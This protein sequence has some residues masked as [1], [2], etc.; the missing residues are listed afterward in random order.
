MNIFVSVLIAVLAIAVGA[1]L[2]YFARQSIA[3]KQAD[4]IETTLQKRVSQV[5]KETDE[6]LA[7]AKKKADQLIESTNKETEAQKREIFNTERVLLKRENILGE[8]ISNLEEK[9][10]E[11]RQKVEKLK[12]VKASLETLR[13]EVDTLIVI[14]NQRLMDVIGKP[15]YKTD[16]R[17]KTNEA[18][19]KKGNRAELNGQLLAAITTSLET[20]IITML[21]RFLPLNFIRLT[22][23]L[24]SQF[25]LNV[26]VK[27]EEFISSDLNSEL[28]F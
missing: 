15:E 9:E 13:E 20:A 2:G 1:V 24:L 22:E 6:M 3:R 28:F 21:I 7:E 19:I 16:S 26:W 8:R 5:K 11:F 18:R 25:S 23:V 27:T 4:N 12:E 14:P 10:N 17:F